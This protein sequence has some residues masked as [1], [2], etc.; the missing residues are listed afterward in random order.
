MVLLPSVLLLI[1]SV[2]F[3]LFDAAVEFLKLL[4]VNIQFPRRP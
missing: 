4:D 2:L 1:H 3:I